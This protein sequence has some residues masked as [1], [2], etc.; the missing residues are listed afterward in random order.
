MS[1]LRPKGGTRAERVAANNE[2]LRRFIAEPEAFEHQWRTI[3]RF[4]VQKRCGATHSYGERCEAYMEF[5]V[6]EVR[7]EKLRAKKDGRK[8]RS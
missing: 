6:A 4:L 8:D 1:L 2:W 5:L 7:A 3:D